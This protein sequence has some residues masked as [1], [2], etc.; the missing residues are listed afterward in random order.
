MD[1]ASSS[2]SAP[3]TSGAQSTDPR[4]WKSGSSLGS[5]P[6]TCSGFRA[7]SP[8]CTNLLGTLAALGGRTWILK[9]NAKF[10]EHANPIANY[11]IVFKLHILWFLHYYAFETHSTFTSF[12][13][14][15]FQNYFQN[16][17]KSNITN[18]SFF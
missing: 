12:F 2:G 13:N 4:P 7:P 10:G 16:K 6:L 14:S 5:T 11:C 3:R 18:W 17:L 9:T 8:T 1:N 15:F